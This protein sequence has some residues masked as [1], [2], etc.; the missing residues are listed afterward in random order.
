MGR[1]NVREEPQ[2]SEDRQ[3]SRRVYLSG[4]LPILKK[5][6]KGTLGKDKRLSEFER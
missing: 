4:V 6:E 2:E 5:I 3:E 1:R